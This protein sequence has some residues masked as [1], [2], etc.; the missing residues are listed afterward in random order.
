MQVILLEQMRKLGNAGELVE[1]KG[2]YA[3]N[4]LIPNK[5]ALRATKDNVSYF[6]SKKA[7]IE[8]EN[9][10]KL[11]EATAIAKKIEG[12]I[13]ALVRQAGEDGRL[14]GSVNAADIAKTATETTKQEIDRKQITLH[15]PI[16]YIGV[17]SIEISLFGTVVAH[18]NVNIARTADEAKDQESRFKKGEIV[19]EGP[20]AEAE[21][22]EEARSAEAALAPAPKEEKEEAKKGKADKEEAKEDK[23]E[24]KA[25]KK[26]APAKAEPKKKAAAKKETKKEESK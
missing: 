18:V 2:G 4:Y 6:E 8:K 26:A 21:K 7:E 24:A 5:K 25:E 3:R 10:K 20:A 22:K 13:V 23:K 9:K 15:N 16:K 1:V 12:A 14:Y 17:H 11:D 19:M